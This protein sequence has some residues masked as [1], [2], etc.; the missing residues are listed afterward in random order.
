MSELVDRLSIELLA[1][2][3]AIHFVGIG[4]IGMSGLADLLH[5]NGHSISG[6]DQ[7]ASR[8][9][10]NL[11]DQGVTVYRGHAA[12]H[13]S[14]NARMLVRSSAVGDNNVE[15]EEARRRGLPVY[16]RGEVFAAFCMIRRLVAVCGTHGKTT[17]SAMLA[18]LLEPS[19]A[20]WFVGG[21][22]A[23]LGAVARDAQTGRAFVAEC[24]ES[25]GTLVHYRPEITVVTN[26]E[27]DH[28]E[29]FGGE[30]DF[31]ECFRTVLARSGRVYVGADDPMACRLAPDAV[32]AGV[33]HGHFQAG[34][35]R[36]EG[37]GS[38]FELPEI[39]RCSLQVP[40]EH[41]VKNAIL[42]ARV[43]LALGVPAETIRE[44]LA[45]FVSVGRRFETVAEANGIHVV[46]DY[47]HHP[48]EIRAVLDAAAGLK[49]KRILAVYQPHR[50]TRTVAL[51]QDFPAAFRGIDHLW[52]LPVY[53]ASEAPVAGGT[54]ED[55]AAECRRQEVACHLEQTVE[56]AWSVVRE[57][58]RAGDLFLILGAGDVVR[59]CGM[60]AL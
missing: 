39:G 2:K 16:L 11:A 10:E 24:D 50:Y 55:L 17:T 47:A 57:E 49:P 40:G 33:A 14:R 7:Q 44:R 34:G 58:L 53:A 31:L 15:V 1:K 8:L 46:S 13:V 38:T 36:M 23:Q 28:M 42:A 20:G 59:M 27:F 54:S 45:S 41:N 60:V 12:G 19:G 26:V 48:T 32:G 21:E 51:L 5:A 29:T 56:S 4:G 22:S 30:D 37:R 6:S 9:T 3:P 52:L 25:D 35:L 18:H 43:A